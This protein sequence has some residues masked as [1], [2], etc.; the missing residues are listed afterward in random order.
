MFNRN[1][2]LL[3][4]AALV[5]LGACNG[6]KDGDK[7][8]GGDGDGTIKIGHYASLTGKEATFGTQVE[9][10]IQLA[11]DEINAAGGVLGRKLEVIT[12]DT[13]SQTQPAVNAVEKLISR[14]DV[15]ALLGEV[16]SGRTMAAA[17]ISEREKVPMLTP[18][19]TNEKVTIAKDG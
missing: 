3:G 10:G 7:P 18:A 15:V 9:N 1:V 6:G 19:S 11:L 5:G 12:E 4:L 13:Q 2:L 8:D 17:P 14:D 16:A